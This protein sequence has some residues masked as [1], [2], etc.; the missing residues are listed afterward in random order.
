MT[1]QQDISLKSPTI[2]GELTLGIKVIDV[3]FNSLSSF[4]V[5]KKS[6]TASETSFPTVSLA[7]K[8]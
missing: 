2:L 8:K 6:R 4:P 7:L 3:T 5:S 1:K